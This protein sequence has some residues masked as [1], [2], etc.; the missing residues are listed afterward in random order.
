MLYISYSILDPPVYLS[1]TTEYI[2]CTA[3]T[4]L[5]PNEVYIVQMQER[6]IRLLPDELLLNGKHANRVPLFQIS[7][8]S[9]LLICHIYTNHVLYHHRID[10]HTTRPDLNPVLSWRQ[11]SLAL[12]SSAPHFTVNWP[13]HAYTYFQEGMPP[14][15]FGLFTCRSQRGKS[16]E[17]YIHDSMFGAS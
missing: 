14:E 11:G 6:I 17:N 8:T 4:S 15:H 2:G 7:S 9:Y 12:N 13:Y 10:C 5:V 16:T 3:N 1:V